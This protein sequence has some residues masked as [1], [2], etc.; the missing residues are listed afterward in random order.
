MVERHGFKVNTFD[1]N[2]AGKEKKVD[3]AIAH[4][5]TKD[6]Y[7][8]VIA[9]KVDEITLVAGDKDFV[10]VVEDLVS[11][12]FIV[13]VVFWGHAAAELKTTATKF[14]NLNSYL[15]LLTSRWVPNH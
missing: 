5:M 3:V 14:I 13:H 7:S 9:P 12:N 10:P 6:A 2:A 15:D 4:Q 11:N 8:G 1:R